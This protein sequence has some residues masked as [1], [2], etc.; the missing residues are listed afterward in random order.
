MS[1]TENN[2]EVENMSDNSGCCS[3]DSSCCVSKQKKE[4]IDQQ[5]KKKLTIDFLFLDLTVCGRCQG[6]ETNLDRAIAEVSGVLKAAGYEVV[7]NKVNIN[8]K[9]LAVKHKFLSSPTIR[10]DGSD[11]AM[12]V[13]ES[14]CRDCGDLCGDGDVECRVWVYEGVEY[15][16]P[17]KEMIVNAVLKRVYG[18]KHPEAEATKNYELPE[19]MK[20]F[21]EGKENK[22]SNK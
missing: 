20:V 14:V 18:D 9:E 21:F 7:V 13:K 1:I 3:G 5:T 15:D 6:A 4:Q 17:P 8:S 16:E 10:I 11:I 12:E 2:C 19:N 22:S